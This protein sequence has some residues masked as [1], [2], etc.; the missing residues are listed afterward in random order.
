[1]TNFIRMKKAPDCVSGFD[2]KKKLTLFCVLASLPQVHAYTISFKSETVQEKVQQQKSI[3]GQIND[4]NGMPIPGATVSIRD[5]KIGTITD[6][7]GKFT[8]K[9]DAN[10]KVLVVSSVGY[11]TQDIV[12]GS[13]T[14]FKIALKPSSEGLDEVVVVGYGTQK[15]ESLVSAITTIPVGEIKGPS[16]NLTTMMA[17][18]VSGMIAYQRSGEPGADNSDFFIRGLGSFGAGKVNPLILI[19]GVESS[20]TDMAR[21]QPDDIEAFSVL[22]DASAASIYGARGANGVVLITTKSGKAGKLKVRF[23]EENKLSSNTRNFKFADNITYM[24]LANEAV[25]TRNP[26]GVLPYSQIKIDR[27]AAG[28]DPIL[29]P[30]NN[31]IDQLIKDYT[32]NQG[33]NLSVSGGSDKTQYYVASTYNIDNGVL[34]VDN[35]NNFNNNIK[36]RN[37]SF[38]SNVNIKLT[39][40]TEGIIRFYSQFDDYTGP[41]G[42]G[43][44]L[45]NRAIWSNPVAFPAVYPSKYLPYIEHPLFG[46]AVAGYGSTTLLTNPYA[47][48][49]RGYQV[50]KASTIQTQLELKQDLKA[51]TQG[52]SARAMA[53]V[54]RYSFYSLSRQ[55]NPFYYNATINPDT[56]EVFLNLLNPGGEGSIGIAGT[57][58]LNYSEGTKNL[59]SEIYLQTAINY[60]RTFAE[61]HDVSGML[62]NI[63]QNTESGNPGSLQASLPSR[64]FGLSGR[65]TYGYDKRYL[66]E[67]NFGYNGSE[68]FAKNNRYGFFPSLALGYVVSNEKFFEPLLNVVSNLKFRASFGWVGNDQIGDRTDR[69]FYLSNV[70]LN[71]GTYGA[72]FGDLNGYYRNGVSISRYANDKISWERSKQI[73]IGMDLKLFNSIDIVIDAFKQTRSNI[74]QTR[75]NIGSTLGLSVTPATNFGAAESKGLDMSINYNKHFGDNWFT[76]LRGNLTYSTSKILKYDENYYPPELS[77]LYRKGN[78]I[79]QN[80]G[81]IAERLFVDDQEAANSPK[82]FGVYGGGDIKYRDVNGDGVISA[83]DKMPIGYPTSPEIIYGFGGTLGY[84]KFDFSIFFQGS[85]RSSFFINPQNISPFV[86]N[87]GAQNGLLKVVADD[88]WSEDNRNLYAFWPRLS[89]TFIENNNQVSTWWMR[90]GA[91]LRLKSVELGYNVS[92]EFLDKFK[93]SSLRLYANTMN[94]VVFSQFKL[95]DPEMGGNGLGYPIQV[96]YNFGILLDL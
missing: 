23:R 13:R 53:Y 56:D 83:L 7:D 4:E 16:S 59:N 58:Y 42:G 33:Y 93:I 44:A 2:L 79:A 78:S 47:E 67:F 73:N 82:Q 38:R 68:R 96:T 49:V 72:S 12:I 69:F 18:R 89:N 3:S 61:K 65:F 5:S 87:G 94:P 46:G 91:F 9:L 21:L 48:M 75:S 31:W 35:L 66:A 19:D 60:N 74:L 76:N 62:I 37:Y 29:Y 77:Y 11:T 39:P 90:N 84:K 22:K 88:H 95:W 71:D 26:I 86:T 32:F 40:S 51:I 14:D 20:T 36:L 80:Y 1:M 15:K 63:L 27:T 25:L 28:A 10:S 17:G 30:N 41:V 92:K 85:A 34:K 50:S 24:N 81:Y 57:E 45:F 8:L 55:Y 64:N 70:N 6:F 54:R 52:L 43:T